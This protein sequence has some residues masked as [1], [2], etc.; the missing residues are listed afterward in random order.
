MLSRSIFAGSHK[1]H[2]GGQINM[3]FTL[4]FWSLYLVV[5]QQ[6]DQNVEV[7]CM[8]ICIEKKVLSFRASHV[9]PRMGVGIN[10][11]AVTAV[12][13]SIKPPHFKSGHRKKRADL[14]CFL[15]DFF[16]NLHFQGHL[17]SGDWSF[18]KIDAASVYSSPK[19]ISK[20]EKCHWHHPSTSC[21]VS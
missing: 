8:L 17:K 9:S 14:W 6:S 10:W 13:W 5:P 11:A 18:L 2:G 4:T 19:F 7:K 1:R 21:W 15:R 12:T 3:H 16:S 20:L